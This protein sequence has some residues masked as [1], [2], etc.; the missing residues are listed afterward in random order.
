VAE[1]DKLTLGQK[2]IVQVPHATLPF[3]EYKG[4]YQLTSMHIT[5]YQSMLCDNLH[6]SI[7]TVKILNLATLL[8]VHPGGPDHDCTEV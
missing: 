8:P 4:Q 2:L 5:K 6:I 1:A 3:V 7:N